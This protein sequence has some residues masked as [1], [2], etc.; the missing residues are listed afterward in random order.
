MGII[1]LKRVTEQ[2][3]DLVYDIETQPGQWPYSEPVATPN[4]DEHEKEHLDRFNNGNRYDFFVY[5]GQVVIGIGYIWGGAEP[6][7]EWEI[8]YVISHP[9]RQKGYGYETA[10][11]LLTYGFEDL[12]A[13][14]IF[15]TCNAHNTASSRILQKLGMRHE[16]VFK[17]KLFWNGKWTDQLFYA[18]LDREYITGGR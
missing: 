9:Y 6:R 3:I 5:S 14:R 16:A 18:I 10:K 13:H 15:A 2:D 1:C 7:R 4:R 11:A 8:A 17:E 12:D